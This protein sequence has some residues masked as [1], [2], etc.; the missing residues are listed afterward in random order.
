MKTFYNTILSSIQKEIIIGSLLGDGSL[1]VNKEG[2]SRNWA[3]VKTQAA[4]P[5]KGGNPKPSRLEYLQWHFDSFGDFSSSLNFSKN[6]DKINFRTKTHPIFTEMGYAWYANN[7][8]KFIRLSNGFKCKQIPS[9]IILTP[10]TMA[11][12]FCDDGINRPQNKNAIL[13]TDSFTKSENELLIDKIKNSFGITSF[14]GDRNRITFN[15]PS[16]FDFLDMIRPYIIWDCFKYKADISKCSKYSLW[17]STHKFSKL[18]ESDIV[19]MFKLKEKGKSVAEIA[20]IFDIA[21]PT[22][23]NILRRKTWKHVDSGIDLSYIRNKCGFKGVYPLNG[24]KWFA[25]FMIDGKIYKSKSFDNLEDAK[26]ARMLL[27]EKYGKHS[28]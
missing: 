19:F 23:H 6:K 12:W 26:T 10:L 3:F 14:L 27:E 8:G 11:V 9:D 18:K 15:Q 28:T 21:K 2:S 25:S 1:T 24:K 5:N 20:D 17:G 4:H 7:D 13:C 16:Y 22:V